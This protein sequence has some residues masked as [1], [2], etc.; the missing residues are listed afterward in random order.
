MSDTSVKFLRDKK[1]EELPVYFGRIPIRIMKLLWSKK[2]FRTLTSVE[3]L[4]EEFEF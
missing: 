3:R 1:L 4:I 2:K